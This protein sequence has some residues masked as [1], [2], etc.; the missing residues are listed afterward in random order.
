VIPD[1][2]SADTPYGAIPF[3]I[4][5]C[6]SLLSHHRELFRKLDVRT[7]EQ[8][9]SLEMEFPLLTYVFG[10]T[11]FRI[12]P[13]IVDGCSVEG[14]EKIANALREFTDDPQ[15]L[16]V[17]SSDFCHWG[18][19]FRYTHLPSGGGQIYERIE[20][21]DREAA[22]LIASG[23]PGRFAAYLSQTRNTI[24][25]RNAILV[26]MHLYTA[27]RAEFPAYSRS[28]NITSEHDS[29]VSYFA[30]IIRTET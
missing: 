6:E 4:E 19:R 11:A 15:T 24:C 27:F 20:R 7:A 29:C 16:V 10:R 13:I 22:E 12:V 5:C 28:G 17:V 21:L 30:G 1:A 25:G 2:T 8:E 3:D 18:E 26:M 23:K 14:A 9:H